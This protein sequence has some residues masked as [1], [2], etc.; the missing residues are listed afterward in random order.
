MSA[1]QALREEELAARAAATRAWNRLRTMA[2]RCNAAMD[3]DEP[4]PIREY[5]HAS[6]AYVDRMRIWDAQ[7]IALIRATRGEKRVG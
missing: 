3:N 5:E 2:N 1:R 6:A 7:R 4:P